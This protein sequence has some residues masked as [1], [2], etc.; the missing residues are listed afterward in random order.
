[1]VNVSFLVDT[2]ASRTCVAPSDLLRFG[3]GASERLTLRADAGSFI[4]VGGSVTVHSIEGALVFVHDSGDITAFGLELNLIFDPSANALPSI[5]GR[6]VLCKGL[7]AL[8]AAGGKV[9][10]DPPVG[11]FQ[12]QHD[13]GESQT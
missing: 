8:D 7:L 10:F 5:L 12:I 2:G 13:Q 6:E 11:H 1:M 3:S 9:S 4:G